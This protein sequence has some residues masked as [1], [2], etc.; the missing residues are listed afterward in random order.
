MNHRKGAFPSEHTAAAAPSVP[1]ARAFCAICAFWEGIS[2]AEGR[3]LEPWAQYL[4]SPGPA[5]QICKAV[6]WLLSKAFVRPLHQTS[7]WGDEQWA[8]LPRQAGLSLRGS[9]WGAQLG[10]PAWGAQ[11]WGLSLGC[12]AWR[13]QPWE[14]S[15]GG[16]A[17]GA[18]PQGLTAA[19]SLQHSQLQ[20][21][22]E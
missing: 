19:C 22:S 2:P 8:K 16:S 14:L 7:A 9:A 15:P 11:H 1:P 12:S 6:L 17:Q 5:V 13:A 20:L 3:L 18:Q 21:R 4:L 10:G